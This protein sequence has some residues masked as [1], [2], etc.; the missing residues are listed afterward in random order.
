MAKKDKAKDWLACLN[1]TFLSFVP[2]HQSFQ[3]SVEPTKTQT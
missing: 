3:E 1:E 2:P